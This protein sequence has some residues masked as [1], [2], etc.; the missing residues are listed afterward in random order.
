MKYLFLG[1]AAIALGACSQDGSDNN[2][3]NNTTERSSETTNR[4]NAVDADGDQAAASESLDAILDSQP[5]D[6]KARY[7]YRHPKETL[8]FFGVEP[9]MTVVD[10]L[11]GEPG[12]YGNILIPYLGAEGKLIGADY[13]TEMWPLF[14]NFATP[15]FLENRQTWS[16]QFI[17][18]AQDVAGEDGPQIDAFV[19]GSAPERL[20]GTADV[21]LMMRAAH[22]F[23][24]LEDGRFFTE[25]LDD[26]NMI[27]KP[28]GIVGVVQHRAPEDTPDEWAIG[29]A[30]YVKQTQIVSVFENAGFEL[31]DESEI[32]A[33]PN[34]QP[35]TDDIVW[36]L[37]P[38][39]ATSGDNPELRAEMQA[40]GESDRM[41][42]KF[43]KPE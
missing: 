37:P 19:Y 10:S 25:A 33:N 1:V 30:G 2:A 43:R 36:R 42:L 7:Q 28:G 4:N 38:S 41:T 35:T 27:L 12:W 15:E 8:E 17:T 31:V 20:A 21:V 24:R 39:L 18:A 40:I 14:T 6:V 23:N 9:G 13:S 3:G 29:D 11:P 22:H 16:E 32:N 34:D 26:I 5:D